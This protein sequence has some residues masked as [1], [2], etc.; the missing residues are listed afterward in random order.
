[1]Q[2]W[3]LPSCCFCRTSLACRH[4]LTLADYADCVRVIAQLVT[5]VHFHLK[6][7]I[8]VG[9]KKVKDVQFYTEVRLTFA[10]TSTHPPS[11]AIGHPFDL[12]HT[13]YEHSTTAAAVDRWG[14]FRNF[15]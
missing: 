2:P 4:W 8:M 3:L 6:D 5:L 7:P 10:T 14:P 11:S 12:S 1:M 15:R 9:K 13:S